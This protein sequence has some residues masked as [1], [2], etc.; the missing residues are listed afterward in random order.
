MID[1]SGQGRGHLAVCT[2]DRDLQFPFRVDTGAQ[3]A[4]T[5]P[6]S[7]GTGLGAGSASTRCG[8]W[9]VTGFGAMEMSGGYSHDL[10]SCVMRAE[11]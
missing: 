3:P 6:G 1:V 5:D 11:R 7:V 10:R 2:V 4:A 9:P 8:V